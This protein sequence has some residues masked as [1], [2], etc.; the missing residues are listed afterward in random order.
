LLGVEVD[1]VA[2]SLV[3]ATTSSR[4]T[5]PNFWADPASGIS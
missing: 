4:F 3:A 2:K 5:V 1:D